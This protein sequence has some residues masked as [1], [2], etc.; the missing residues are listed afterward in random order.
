MGKEYD[1]Y[2]YGMLT[3]ENVQEVA[4]LLL[5]LLDKKRYAFV[6]AGEFY[7]FMPKVRTNQCLRH[8]DSLTGKAINVYYSK[9]ENPP[10]Y[11]GFNVCDT[12]GVWGC[13]TNL[14]EDIYDPSFNNPYLTFE[15]NRVT[16]TQRT[17]AG[18]LLYWV[19]AIQ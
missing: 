4:D 2:W 9:K 15:N 5:Q 10:K 17:P 12:H 6:G 8:K 1:L 16:I 18:K 3:I 7:D 11:A 19:I 13:S 14:I